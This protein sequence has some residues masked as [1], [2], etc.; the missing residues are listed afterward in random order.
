MGSMG[1]KVRRAQGGGS[2]FGKTLTQLGETTKQVTELQTHLAHLP[3]VSQKLT[4]TGKILEAVINDHEALS[5][6]NELIWHIL[7]KEL[8]L[9]PEKEAKYRQEIAEARG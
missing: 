7:R 9:T 1:R 4:D 8:A 6:E 3:E 2:K 5:A